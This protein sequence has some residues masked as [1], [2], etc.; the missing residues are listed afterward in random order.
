MSCEAGWKRWRR[1]CTMTIADRPEAFSVEAPA[2]VTLSP[3]L[4]CF[5]RL[6]VIGFDGPVSLASNVQRDLVERWHQLSDDDYELAVALAW[7]SRGPMAA[8]L[9]MA[10]GSFTFG[11]L[12]ETLAGF[13]CFCRVVSLFS[14][15][16]QPSCHFS[17]KEWFRSGDGSTTRR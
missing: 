7:L 4:K 12:G 13:V 14:A 2:C 8:R 5:L 9:A 11:V 17:T 6:G 3:I 10:L 16:I 1:R 15:V